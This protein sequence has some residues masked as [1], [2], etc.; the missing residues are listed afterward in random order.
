MKKTLNLTIIL[1]M[2]GM[3]IVN[4]PVV[5]Q[6]NDPGVG[7]TTTDDMD[8]DDGNDW[9]WIGLLGLI[10]LYG[11]RGKKEH[12]STTTTRTPITDR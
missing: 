9:G 2:A 1:A 5:S 3:L 8:D 4:H 11:L 6:T 7:T 12:Y 10:G